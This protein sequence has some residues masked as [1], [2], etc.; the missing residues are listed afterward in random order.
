MGHA[1]RLASLQK[2]RELRAAGIHIEK[3]YKRSSKYVDYN[4][5]IPF[6]RKAPRGFYDT[7]NDDITGKKITENARNNFKPMYLTD[8]EGERRDAIEERERKKDIQRQKLLRK[9]NLPEAILRL[10]RVNNIDDDDVVERKDI[11]LPE[12]MITDNEL[13]KIGKMDNKYGMFMDNNNGDSVL[14]TPSMITPGNMTNFNGKSKDIRTPLTRSD[15]VLE[16]SINAIKMNDLETPLLGGMNPKIMNNDWSGITPK[17]S[18]VRTPNPLSTPNM[19]INNESQRIIDIN[20]KKYRNKMRKRL[21]KD[22]N[23]LPKPMHDVSD[24]DIELPIFDGKNSVLFDKKYNN[25]DM[26]WIMDQ[27]EVDSNKVKQMEIDK[28]NEWNKNTKVIKDNLPVPSI[29]NYNK[30]TKTFKDD[31]LNDASELIHNEMIKLIQYDNN[32]KHNIGHKHKKRKL[33]PK[34]EYSDIE[35]TNADQL[36]KDEMNKLR[37]LHENEI[38]GIN[39]NKIDNELNFV[40]SKKTYGFIG[41]K[42]NETNVALKREIIKQEFAILRRHVE[43]KMNRNNKMERNYNTL[44]NGYININ[45][46]LVKNIK[47]N[48][49]KI[50]DIER[51]INIYNK[52]YENEKIAIKKRIKEY[53]LRIDNQRKRENKLKAEWIKIK[54]QTS[55]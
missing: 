17:T 4:N 14:N 42:N 44:T 12:P 26:D 38:N 19:N 45:K 27:T 25:I 5:E 54:K 51:E 33:M 32:V 55:Q 31:E 22:L 43:L 36:L 20:N 48:F 1:R 53:K 3:K 7:T 8:I 24:Y 52:L 41:G 23:E 46:K 50:K 49:N 40:P 18:V 16:Q 2:R 47:N 35:L 21:F 29:V 9:I 15:N 30:I 34:I 37:K 10:N 28:Q 13:N 11:I 6:Y 39:W